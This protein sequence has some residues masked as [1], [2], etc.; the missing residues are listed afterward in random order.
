MKLS[1]LKTENNPLKKCSRLPVTFCL[2]PAKTRAK[3]ATRNTQHRARDQRKKGEE[4]WPCWSLGHDPSCSPPAAQWSWFRPVNPWGIFQIALISDGALA[5]V[6]LVWAL[7]M[8]VR[9]WFSLRAINAPSGH[10]TILS[11]GNKSRRGCE[12]N[13]NVQPGT[14]HKTT[15]SWLFLF[16][17][18][19]ECT[20]PTDYHIGKNAAS[21]FFHQKLIYWFSCLCVKRLSGR[22]H[23]LMEAPRNQWRWSEKSK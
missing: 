2:R 6:S 17:T 15:T 19:I 18:P 9:M 7:S 11:F 4:V 23:F 16:R 8:L 14:F 1:D 21:F 10:S 3:A 5:R 13:L 12:S 20:T 22:V